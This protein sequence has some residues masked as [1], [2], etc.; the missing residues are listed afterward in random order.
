MMFYT[1]LWLRYDG[2]PYYV[3]KGILQRAL[4]KGSPEGRVIL[5]EHP[6][7]NDAFVA[8]KFL[9]A[10][11]GRKD[12]GMGI[13]HNLTDGGEGVTGLKHSKEWVAE[14]A[15]LRTQEWRNPL[16][17]AKRTGNTGHKA[18][19]IK[20]QRLSESHKGIPQS[21]K[22]KAVLK[23]VRARKKTASWIEKLK[24]SWTPARRQRQSDL[25]WQ[26]HRIQI[27]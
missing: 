12:L 7:E 25:T 5:Q 6:C 22:C 27:I 11:Y 23:I 20:L 15:A 16:I 4:R 24:R 26:R 9:I 13:L 18:S 1:Y 19:A 21:E 8:E 2:T 3:G 14:S 17:R 10:Y